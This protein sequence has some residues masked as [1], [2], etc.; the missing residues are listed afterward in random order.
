MLDALARLARTDSDPPLLVVAVPPPQATVS[1]LMQRTAASQVGHLVRFL[2]RCPR[3]DM[4][5][6]FAGAEALIFCSL[7]EGFGMPVVEAMRMGCPVIAAN[8]TSLPE[9][10]GDAALLVD[11]LDAD[12]I[13]AAVLR[14]RKD[15]ALRRFLVYADASGG[16]IFVAATLHGD[17]GPAVSLHRSACTRHRHDTAPRTASDHE[18]P[19]AWRAVSSANLSRRAPAPGRGNF[20]L[21]RTAS[22]ASAAVGCD[23][24]A[25]P[26]AHGYDARSARRMHAAASQ[27]RSRP[28]IS[29][30]GEPGGQQTIRAR[31][32]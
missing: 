14:L 1:Q 31:S 23:D 26:P 22:I 29:R 8:A 7:Y 27:S 18:R 2:G 17:R 32:P 16:T 9:V 12:A 15:P 21:A 6:L 19:L 10:A 11:P 13:A 3:E 24:H 25:A 5:A 4:P 30:L 28:L 20:A